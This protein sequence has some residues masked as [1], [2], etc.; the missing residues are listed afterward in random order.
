MLQKSWLHEQSEDNKI[1]P[2]AAYDTFLSISVEKAAF[3]FM[4]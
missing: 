4:Q 1:I 3:V 2:G